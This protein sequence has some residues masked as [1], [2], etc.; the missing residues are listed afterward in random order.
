MRKEKERI[1]R[2]KKGKGVRGKYHIFPHL[3]TNI[4]QTPIFYA[5]V[6]STLGNKRDFDRKMPTTQPYPQNAKMQPNSPP[7]PISLPTYLSNLRLELTPPQNQYNPL[8]LANLTKLY[9]TFCPTNNLS[10]ST[11]VNALV[12]ATP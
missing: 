10:V 1:G 12:S 11:V 9:G 6:K 8:P 3:N 7:S 5:R 2:L 4:H